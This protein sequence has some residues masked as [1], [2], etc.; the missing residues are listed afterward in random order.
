MPRLADALLNVA[1][2]AAGLVVLVLLYGLVAR[3]FTPRTDPRRAANPESLLGDV[4]QVEVRN[5]AGEGG[6]AGTLTTYLRRRGF[7]VIES[8]N[9]SSFDV[10]SSFVVDRVGNPAAA[11]RVA[12]AVGVPPSRIRQD[13]A[14]RRFLDVSV[15]IGRDYP[16]LPAFSAAP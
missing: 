5:G 13:T 10:D 14:Q 1:L 3:T 12:A 6:L 7:D 2:A 11:A 9:H 8:G 15:V 4:I 16:A